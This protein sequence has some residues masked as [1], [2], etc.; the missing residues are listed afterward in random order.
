MDRLDVQFASWSCDV[1]TH[2]P[3]YGGFEAGGSIL[4]EASVD[5]VRILA[6]ADFRSECVGGVLE[7]RLG[8]M[9]HDE[10]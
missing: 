7:L 9:P 8:W 3:K 1:A 10:P 5:A 6:D 2:G 4:L